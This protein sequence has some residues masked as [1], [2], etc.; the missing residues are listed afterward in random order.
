[1][2]QQAGFPPAAIQCDAQKVG[3]LQ[4]TCH[5]LF[6]RRLQVAQGAEG[7]RLIRSVASLRHWFFP[8]FPERFVSGW[9]RFLMPLSSG[10][11]T[12]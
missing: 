9:W 4:T 12:L 11:P 3:D 1:M 6:L 2:K 10:N 5:V 7:G 8:Y